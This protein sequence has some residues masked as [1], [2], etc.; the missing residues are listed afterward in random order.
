M[1]YR[2]SQVLCTVEPGCW[3]V[4]GRI[5]GSNLLGACFV[6]GYCYVFAGL[7]II[8][9]WYICVAILAFQTQELLGACIYHV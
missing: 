6:M 5:R 2:L 1:K 9:A 7:R 4:V 8:V 3:Q